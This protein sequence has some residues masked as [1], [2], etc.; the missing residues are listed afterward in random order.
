MGETRAERA[1]QLEGVALVAGREAPREHDLVAVAGGDVLAD[2]RHRSL[3]PGAVPAVLE[4]AEPGGRAG[5]RK[6]ALQGLGERIGPLHRRPVRRLDAGVHRQMDRGPDA[7]P[8]AQVV[9]DGTAVDQHP[10]AVRKVRIRP[11][12]LGDARLEPP[13]RAVA[14]VPHQPTDEGRGAVGPR[15][16]EG[17]HQLAERLERRELVLEGARAGLLQGDAL[18]ALADQRDGLVAEERVPPPAFPALDRLEQEGVR[19]RGQL[20]ERADRGLGVPGE[21]APHRHEV[22]AGSESLEAGQAHPGVTHR[23]A[24]PTA[25]PL[26]GG[27]RGPGVLPAA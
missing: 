18:G 6:R 26:A 27:L 3:E 5:R 19:R 4:P 14:E 25:K 2:P 17:I 15:E 22:P 1:V 10:L 13:H 11:V 7:E 24:D 8:V 20:E 21:L 23:A 12:P 16:L 9:E